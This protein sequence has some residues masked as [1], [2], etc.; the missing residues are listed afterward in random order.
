MRTR[1]AAAASALERHDLADREHRRRSQSANLLGVLAMA[2][3]D[4]G[5]IVQQPHFERALRQFRRAIVF[6]ANNV[7]AKRNL[8][9]LLRRAVPMGAR[10]GERPTSGRKGRARLP[11]PVAGLSPSGKGY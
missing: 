7:A 6:D 4:D 3:A 1:R 2:N 11:R 10:V 5:R 8:E 9:R